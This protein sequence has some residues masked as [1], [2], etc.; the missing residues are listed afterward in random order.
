MNLSWKEYLRDY[1]NLKGLEDFVIDGEIEL[2]VPHHKDYIV[3]VHHDLL[4]ETDFGRSQPNHVNVYNYIEEIVTINQEYT[5]FTRYSRSP[6][7]ANGRRFPTPSEANFLFVIG[8]NGPICVHNQVQLLD[9]I[10]YKVV[11]IQN[12]IVG[13]IEGKDKSI[14]I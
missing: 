6:P 1:S 9:K 11:R 13:P 7:S 4:V 12:L 8:Y 2:F 14:V 5:F 3:A 10:G